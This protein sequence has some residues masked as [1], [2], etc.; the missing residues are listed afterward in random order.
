MGR[1]GKQPFAVAVALDGGKLDLRVYEAENKEEALGLTMFDLRLQSKS[2][3][4]ETYITDFMVLPAKEDGVEEVARAEL[5]AGR[6]IGA[7]KEVRAYTGWGLREAKE[8]VDGLLFREPGLL[9]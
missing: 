6:R 2:D 3:A 7:I 5:Q 4:L 1:T 8:Y 9:I